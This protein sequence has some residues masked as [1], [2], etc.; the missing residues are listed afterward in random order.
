MAKPI[1]DVGPVQ[2]LALVG[3]LQTYLTY[4]AVRLIGELAWCSLTRRELAP[5][6]SRYAMRSR[7]VA[8]ELRVTHRG[9]AA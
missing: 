7:P 2:A 3:V 9:L 1:I 5:V 4:K 6:K 8:P